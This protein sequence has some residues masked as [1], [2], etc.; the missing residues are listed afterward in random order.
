MQLEATVE[1]DVIRLPADLHLP[2]GTTV[3]VE[4]DDQMAADAAAKAAEYMAKVAWAESPEGGGWPKGY[5]A[6]TAGALEGQPFERPEQGT[7][8]VRENWQ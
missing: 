6:R 4:I 8:E 5:F 1:H 3:K 2:D 7:V